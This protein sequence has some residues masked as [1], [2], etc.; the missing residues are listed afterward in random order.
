MENSPYMDSLVAERA[1]L[2]T[3]EEQLEGLAKGSIPH[4]GRLFWTR[5][6]MPT[7]ARADV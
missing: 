2:L 4:I 6:S 1:M 7:G 5:R 3:E